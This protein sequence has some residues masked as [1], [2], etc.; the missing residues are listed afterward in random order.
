MDDAGVYE[1]ISRGD[2]TGVFQLESSGFK[3][4]LK[5]LRPDCFEDI[6]AAV[7]L[8]RPGPLEGGMVDQFIDCKHGRR[9]DRVP[10]R[11]A[12]GGAEGDLR[13]LRVP[14]AG[15][16]GGA[17]PRRLQPRL[18]RPDAPGDG[19]EE[20]EEMDHQRALRRGL[21]VDTRRSRRRRRTRSST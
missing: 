8:Y 3:D 21:R 20:E 19:Q 11:A 6:I 1:M 15:D 12:G 17:G 7:A 5:K 9:A 4:L 18:R 2:T 10:A 14:G 16:A 13:G